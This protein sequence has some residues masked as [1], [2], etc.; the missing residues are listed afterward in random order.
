MSFNCAVA[1]INWN[2]G[3]AKSQADFH[4]AD[5]RYGPVMHNSAQKK[6]R[7]A[8]RANAL[9]RMFAARQD[10][11]KSSNRR[12]GNT[13]HR[14]LADFFVLFFE[15]FFGEDFFVLLRLPAAFFLVAICITPFHLW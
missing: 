2:E 4:I 14:R 11:P 8:S 9:V 13:N 1:R 10:A 5:W 12:G 7:D 3:S 15:D 6:A